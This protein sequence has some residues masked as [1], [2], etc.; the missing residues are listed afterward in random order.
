MP[1]VI[2]PCFRIIPRTTEETY[3]N[4]RGGQKGDCHTRPI[5]KQR[6]AGPQHITLGSG[7][8]NYVV[9]PMHEIMHTLGCNLF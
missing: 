8:A 3:I 2:I 5:G 6:F 4:F 1:I 9:T 7:C